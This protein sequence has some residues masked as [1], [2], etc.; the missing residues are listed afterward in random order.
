MPATT[1]PIAQSAEKVAHLASKLKLLHHEDAHIV[2]PARLS[3]EREAEGLEVR[4]IPY[5]IELCKR[6]EPKLYQRVCLILE[7]ALDGTPAHSFSVSRKR[8][9]EMFQN[10]SE[11]IHDLWEDLLDL[12]FPVWLEK[13]AKNE[14]AQ[15]EKWYKNKA[16][17]PHGMSYVPGGLQ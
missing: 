8:I 4:Y 3:A 7:K 1:A 16:K 13:K 9:G 14:D 11:F 15:M 17:L 12:V 2:S 5:L 6:M 10:S